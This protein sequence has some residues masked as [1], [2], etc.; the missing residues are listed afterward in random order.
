MA[1]WQEITHLIK[2]PILDTTAVV[3]TSVL[4]IVTDIPMAVAVGLLIGMFLYIRKRP[5]ILSK[6]APGRSP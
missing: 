4:M 2:A 1:N 6:A 3:A 5:A